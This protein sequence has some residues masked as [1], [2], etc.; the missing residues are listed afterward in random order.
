MQIDIMTLF[1][2]VFTEIL[3]T[4]I[5][6]KAQKSGLLTI[7]TV[8]IRDFSKDKHRSVDEPPYGGGGGMVLGPQAVFDAVESVKKEESEV[9]L[10]TPQ[11]KPFNQELAYGLSKIE[12]IILICG[13]Y[14]GVDERIREHL[15]AK[16]ISIGDYVLTGGEAAALVLTDA[17]ARLV[18][19][20][21]GNVE[22]A[23]QDSFS[24]GLL[25]YPQYTRPADYRGVEVPEVLLSGNHG[26]IDSFR[27]KESLRNTLKR[28]A[29][30]FNNYHFSETDLELIR[31]VIKEEMER[32][33][34]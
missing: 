1:P 11:G 18:P 20:V 19:G 23:S 24:M 5:L 21:L 30:L 16:E 17:V 25:E 13:H 12:H 31:E 7:N 33:S 10:L 6:G 8:D 27:K 9:I 32:G 15:A 4:S 26:E 22:S 2:N 34:E 14:E 28:R 3:G 29:D